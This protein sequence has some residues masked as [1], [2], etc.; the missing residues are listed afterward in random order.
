MWVGNFDKILFGS[1]FPV[2]EPK[3]NLD[4]LIKARKN[5]N[6]KYGK[7]FLNEIDFKKIIYNNSRKLIDRL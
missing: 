7:E 5:L 1:D 2:F 6:K 3:Y 4:I